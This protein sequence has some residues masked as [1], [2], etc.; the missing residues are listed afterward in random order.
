[1]SFLYS[2]RTKKGVFSSIPKKF[3]Q[4]NFIAH[5][6]FSID[7]PSH[8]FSVCDGHGENGHLVSYFIKENF[9]SKIVVLKKI[10]SKIE[11][12]RNKLKTNKTIIST[13]HES[14]SE[15]ESNLIESSIDIELS[16]STMIVI[17]IKNNT[18]YVSNIGDS[19][20]ILG[21]QNQF[22]LKK[23]DAIALSQDHKPD[24]LKE[25]ERIEKK[26]G[27]VEIRK[28]SEN[29][30]LIHNLA[31]VWIPHKKTFGLSMS[32]SL[33]DLIA[34]KYGITWEPGIYKT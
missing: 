19:R 4:D 2:S 32:R 14:I 31:R 20:A 24:L 25:K 27:Y 18:I 6:N 30:S 33:G 34:K 28:Y 15:L 12:F 5:P 23:W 7:E 16:G 8:L 3:N 13:L 26:G 22:D 21:R 29:T 11:I 10:K 1:M 17:Y 9:P